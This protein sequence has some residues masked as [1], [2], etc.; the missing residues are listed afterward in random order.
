MKARA[1]SSFLRDLSKVGQ[2]F[3][4]SDAAHRLGELASKLDALKGNPTITSVTRQVANADASSLPSDAA[5]TRQL[6]KILATV[7]KLLII[8]GKKSYVT[9][10]AALRKALEARP[11]VAAAD[12][13]A[14]IAPRPETAHR[15]CRNAMQTDEMRLFAE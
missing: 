13:M 6:I 9:D 4:S 3:E 14:S 8:A 5:N 12:L 1:F 10:V 2:A 15:S 11:D 7:E